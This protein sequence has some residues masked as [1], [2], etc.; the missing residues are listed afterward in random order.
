MIES[1]GWAIV[2]GCL[3]VNGPDCAG[4]L[5]T[6]MIWGDKARCD[7]ELRLSNIPGGQCVLVS[8]VD[9]DEVDQLV[10]GMDEVI[11]MLNKGAAHGN[12]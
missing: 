8:G 4:Y 7:D 10:P 1:L 9:P 2:A 12:I 6:G 3:L 5:A 11:E